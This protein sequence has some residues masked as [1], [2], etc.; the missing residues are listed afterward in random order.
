MAN[1][2]I[3]GSDGLLGSQLAGRFLATSEHHVFWLIDEISFAGAD[4]LTSLV[5]RVYRKNVADPSQAS[6]PEALNARF[7]LAP[8]SHKGIDAG[9][10]NIRNMIPA[11]EVW[12]IG[13]E[14]TE[15]ILNAQTILKQ[16]QDLLS[17]LPMLGARVFNCVSSIYA[18]NESGSAK[19]ICGTIEEEVARQCRMHSVGYRVF[20]TS[21]LV[22]EDHIRSGSGG[23]DVRQLLAAL[24]DVIGEVQERLPEYFDF[25]ALRLL[26]RQDAVVNLIPMDRAVD[27][28]LR[29]AQ[30][31]GALGSCHSI[32]SP[33]NMPVKNLCRMLGKIYGANL[34]M[35][36]DAQQLNGIDRLLAQRFSAQGAAFGQSA[37]TAFLESLGRAGVAPE[38]VTLDDKAWQKLF[39][40]IREKQKSDRAARNARAVE[41][42]KKLAPR[43]IDRKGDPLTYFVAGTEGDYV[44][45]LN[46]LGQG[47]DFWYR[48]IDQLMR[49]HRVIIW[50]TR[51]LEWDTGALKLSDHVE[52]IH[53]ILQQEQVAACHLV[54]WCTGPQAAAEFYFRWPEAVLSMVFLN[55]A[56]R[57]SD[58]LDLETIY[59][60]NLV[61]LCNTLRDHPEM[62]P[63]VMRSLSA[64]PANDIN[65]MD[66]TDS[67]NTA[68][69]VL[70]LTNV[71]LR[72]KVL[73]PYRT[74]KTTL[75]YSR[76]ILDLISNPTVDQAARVDPSILIMSCEFDLVAAPAK[77][78]EAALRFPRNKLVELPGATHYSIYDRTEMVATMLL[79]FFQDPEAVTVTESE[80]QL[81]VTVQ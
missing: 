23:H 47:L 1:I 30:Q 7:T 18:R 36:T 74:V 72:T 9:P 60:N 28:M 16:L 78:R 44:L 26:A 27:I 75:N 58:H 43:T 21:S 32:G 29:L 39:K 49:R 61:K 51:G 59:A 79:R 81:A 4:E 48:L 20:H 67:H 41:L 5:H 53:A 57:L 77:S 3:A 56:F 31:E 70:T 14:N 73:A 17:L 55:S 33:Q 25:Q 35:V 62:A 46:A 69:Q 22:G 19:G 37:T 38:S 12:F 6:G 76:Q 50:E 11:E 63:S 13:G 2:L 10:K 54:G 8:W 65:L 71:D 45:I 40:A 68:K 15:D 66:E 52:D 34:T 80:R 24:D 64:P 42:S